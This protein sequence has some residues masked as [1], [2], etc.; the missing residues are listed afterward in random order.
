MEAV[1]H[2]KVFLFCPMKILKL[3][4][5]FSIF[6]AC[7]EEEE[8]LQI[9]PPTEGGTVEIFQLAKVYAK[10]IPVSNQYF[11]GTFGNIPVSLGRVGEDTL[12]FLVP[13]LD[14]GDFQLKVTTGNQLRTWDLRV[15]NLQPSKDSQVFFESFVKS[16]RELQNRILEVEELEELSNPFGSWIDFFEEKQKLLSTA[17]QKEVAEVLQFRKNVPLFENLHSSFAVPCGTSPEST[18]GSM[19]YK[20]ETVDLS[21]LKHYSKLPKNKPNE[22]IVSGLALSFWYQKLLLELYSKQILACPVLQKIHLAMAGSEKALGKDEILNLE[23][24]VP[25]TLSALGEFKKLAMTDL[26]RDQIGLFSYASGFY[27]KTNY[28]RIFSELTEKYTKDY[29]WQMPELTPESLIIPPDQ[30]SVSFTTIKQVNWNRPELSSTDIKLLNY[31]SDQGQLRFVVSTEKKESVPFSLY[32]SLS[33]GSPF[34]PGFTQKA[35]LS[36]GCG[37]DFEVFLKGKTHVVEVSSSLPF[38]VIWSNGQKDVLS[39]T[40]A[41]GDYEVVVIDQEGCEQRIQFTAPEFGTVTDIDGNVYE[42]VKIGETWWMAENLK[43]TR[44]TTGAAIREASSASDWISATGP[45][46]TLA[47]NGA[48]EDKL[49]NN[50]AA[51]CNIC[52]SGWRLPT[53]EDYT[54]L[55]TIFGILSG[56]YVR[57]VEGWPASFI[58]ANNRSGLRL[59]PIEGRSGYNGNSVLDKEMVTFWTGFG[60]LQINYVSA[61]SK[62]FDG[63]S[64]MIS[65]NPKDGFSVRCVK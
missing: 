35:V 51:C 59:L 10:A 44:L 46:Y 2:S 42:T 1:F 6:F 43:V 57:S 24:K 5:L 32:L 19:I 23:S 49:Y 64:F 15:I 22:A 20:F 14:E 25:I 40:L 54:E 4:L 39:Q 37:V 13:R 65:A 27:G 62:N 58:K 8:A 55:S 34:F 16:A 30:T 52:P 60:D 11:E 21:S 56:P 50:Y 38:Q 47:S 17:E 41:P 29:D 31:I 7:R 9:L 36:P 53:I 26:S 33:N 61:I 28:S 18:V 63:L 3:V 12:V 45:A 48:S